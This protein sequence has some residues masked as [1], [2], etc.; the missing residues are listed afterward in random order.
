M[1]TKTQIIATTRRLRSVYPTNQSIIKKHSALYDD[2]LAGLEAALDNGLITLLETDLDRPRLKGPWRHLDEYLIGFILE[3]Q[4]RSRDDLD[5]LLRR[6]EG[7]IGEHVRL[8]H[9]VRI[10]ERNPDLGTARIGIENVA[11]EQNL[12]GE[13]LARIGGKDDVD[14]LPLHHQCRVPFR[15]V[16]GDPDG[17]EVRN[18]HDC[19]SWIVEKCS[20]RHLQVDHAA[21]YRRLQ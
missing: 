1:A 12:A 14:V 19:G 4:R 15:H 6:Q 9:Y 5:H 2:L 17:A 11:D 10:L 18:R 3:D 8:Q 21:G 13:D 16:R 7:G 20:P